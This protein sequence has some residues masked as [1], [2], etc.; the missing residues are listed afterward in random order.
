MC[1]VMACDYAL[2]LCFS[3][4]FLESTSNANCIACLLLLLFLLFQ[5]SLSL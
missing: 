5:L 3:V 2:D 1:N 4:L